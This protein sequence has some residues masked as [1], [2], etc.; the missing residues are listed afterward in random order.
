MVLSLR[1][2]C[3]P[4]TT[5]VWGDGIVDRSLTTLWNARNWSDVS[6]DELVFYIPSLAAI[7]KDTAGENGVAPF[8]RR[9]LLRRLR[10][11]VDLLCVG[12]PKET[13]DKIAACEAI[14]T[15]QLQGSTASDLFVQCKGPSKGP[16]KDMAVWAFELSA[17][18]SIDRMLLDAKR[19]R[20]RPRPD[21]IC[22][23]EFVDALVASIHSS[24]NGAYVYPEFASA[25]ELLGTGAWLG[26]LQRSHSALMPG[27]VAQ[28]LTEYLCPSTLRTSLEHI[29]HV[30]RFHAELAGG[31]KLLLRRA[32][33]VKAVGNP[34]LVVGARGSVVEAENSHAGGTP[35]FQ[36]MVE[37][38]A[39]VKPEASH[40]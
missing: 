20:P 4:Q 40:A 17:L 18:A 31:V 32:I 6:E 7:E 9:A 23:V 28:V 14:S 26:V 36:K 3:R 12:S 24:I 2:W 8:V 39:R 29:S 25:H 27:F 15:V 1:G 11:S 16:E 5:Y 19:Q 22:T 37:K 35:V 10:S 33:W 30:L 38:L 13:L 34:A 21:A